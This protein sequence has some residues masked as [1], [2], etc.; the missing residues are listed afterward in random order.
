MNNRRYHVNRGNESYYCSQFTTLIYYTKALQSYPLFRACGKRI[1]RPGQLYVSG[2]H[3]SSQNEA[4]IQN[5]HDKLWKYNLGTMENTCELKL[6]G[7]IR[8]VSFRGNKFVSVLNV[9][10]FWHSLFR[11]LKHIKMN[12]DI[13]GHSLNRKLYDTGLYWNKFRTE[14]VKSTLFSKWKHLPSSGS[15]HLNEEDFKNGSHQAACYIQA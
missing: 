15:V 2:S 12:I 1:S 7:E 14:F 9:C 10:V 4:R 6:K 5:W 8:F 13:K 11:T 3:A